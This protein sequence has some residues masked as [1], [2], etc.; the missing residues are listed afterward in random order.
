M[1]FHQVER[2][3]LPCASQV[4]L[5]DCLPCAA[6]AAAIVAAAAAIVAAAVA[7]AVAAVAAALAA[8]AAVGAAHA[9]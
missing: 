8:L 1:Y 6:L 5:P 4:R 3:A 9:Q 7:A 2:L